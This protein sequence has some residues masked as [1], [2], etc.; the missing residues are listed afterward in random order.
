MSPYKNSNEQESIL[1]DIYNPENPQSRSLRDISS[2]IKNRTKGPGADKAI[3]WAVGFFAC[4]VFLFSVGHIKN[5]I[6]KPFQREVSKKL[7]EIDLLAHET[8]LD[9]Y[10][11][12]SD[13]SGKDTD[14]DGLSDYDELEV[15]FTS[16]YLG[17]SD[18]DGFSDK[19]E[20]KAGT[21][22]NC[23]SGTG[24]DRY[25]L[26]S[27]QTTNDSILLSDAASE[28]IAPLPFANDLQ[29]YTDSLGGGDIN[30]LLSLINSGGVLSQASAPE[31]Q[32]E[33]TLEDL[34]E[35]DPEVVR[36]LLVSQGIEKEVLDKVTDAEL[37]DL[38]QDT[39]R[40]L[41]QEP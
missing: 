30:S 16:P 6:A 29:V 28:E 33:P 14:A 20:I 12:I 11:T 9:R 10:G 18:S 41:E 40:T 13:L 39:I 32:G 35:L 8:G 1:N 37:D 24:C 19:D 21:H 2:V 27:R 31:V 36:E 23:I 3:R 17:D 25:S 15:F 34:A 26:G 22:P 38:I 4:F 7:P 5:S